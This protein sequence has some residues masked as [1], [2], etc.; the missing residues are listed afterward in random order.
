MPRPAQGTYPS[1]FS[2]YISQVQEDDLKVAFS[3]QQQVI[4]HF[5][6]SIPESKTTNGY[7]EGKWSL[8]ELLQHIIDTER[9]FNYR[10]LSFARNEKASLPG[11]DE[12]E[13]ASMSDA[14]ARNWKDLCDELIAVR[15]STRFLYDSFSAE[16]QNRSGIGNNNPTTVLAMG[17]ISI[18]HIYHHKKVIEERYLI[19]KV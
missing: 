12:N 17:F 16:T 9:I 10:A 7:A 19:E 11:F 4:E 8:K 18:G 15:K 3:N 6:T 5:F 2:A 13:Y 14:N 1:Y